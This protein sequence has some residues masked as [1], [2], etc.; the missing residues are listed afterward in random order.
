[1]LSLGIAGLTKVHEAASALY[2]IKDGFVLKGPTGTEH[3]FTWAQLRRPLRI[4]DWRSVPPERKSKAMQRVTLI[5]TTDSSLDAALT[6][7]AV[8]SLL[9]AAKDHKC[10]VEGWTEN[11]NE[12]TGIIRIV[13]RGHP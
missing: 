7:E 3:S 9:A 8:R 12:T 5:L 10:S 6:E 13:P 2:I 1:M 4:L 11:P